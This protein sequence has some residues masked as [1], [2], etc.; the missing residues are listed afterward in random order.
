MVYTVPSVCWTVV[1][2]TTIENTLLIVQGTTV[3]LAQ[4]TFFSLLHCFLSL[5][6][7]E[8]KW[9]LQSQY[10]ILLSRPWTISIAQGTRVLLATVMFSTVGI[11]ISLMYRC[12]TLMISIKGPVKRLRFKGAALMVSSVCE[13]QRMEVCYIYVVHSTVPQ[14][15]RVQVSYYHVLL[16]KD[17]QQPKVLVCYCHVDNDKDRQQPK[18]LVCYCQVDNDRDRIQPKVHVSSFISSTVQP[19]NILLFRCAEYQIVLPSARQQPQVQV[20]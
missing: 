5:F 15:H 11:V 2:K 9:R 8:F 14:M 4:S 7:D 16:S 10:A 13:Q 20:C 17:R 12:A 1:P 19:D 6:C 3:L 18:V